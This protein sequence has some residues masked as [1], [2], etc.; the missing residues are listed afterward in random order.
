VRTIRRAV[1]F[2]RWDDNRRRETAASVKPA[3]RTVE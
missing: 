1:P 2:A 3:G